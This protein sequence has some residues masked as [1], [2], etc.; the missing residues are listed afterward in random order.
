MYS[1]LTAA[2]E[3][4]SNR[5]FTDVWDAAAGG[6]KVKALNQAAII[7]DNLNFKGTKSSVYAVLFDS[8]GNEL[9]ST[10]ATIMAADAAQPTEFPRGADTD[11][12]Q[13]I[14]YAQY[15]IAALL[16][17]GWIPDEVLENYRVTRNSYGAVR[18]TYDTE[19]ASNV[20]VLYGVPSGVAWRFLLPFLVITDLIQIDRAD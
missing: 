13:P 6:D 15:E 4:F 8:A 11:V 19:S 7:I 14:L 16:L 10:Q 20:H 3:Y 17:A 18:T 12:P 9:N 2:N 1:T 5:L